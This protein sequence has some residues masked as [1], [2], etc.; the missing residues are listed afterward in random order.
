MIISPTNKIG[1]TVWYEKNGVKSYFIV[2]YIDNNCVIDGED[3]IVGIEEYPTELHNLILP[4]LGG[5]TKYQIRYNNLYNTKVDFTHCI[6]K[7]LV[8]KEE[9]E[10]SDVNDVLS[11][12]PYFCG[13]DA[14]Q[15]GRFIIFN[16]DLTRHE[17]RE[18]ID[19]ILSGE[20]NKL[21]KIFV[22]KIINFYNIKQKE[23][24]FKELTNCP[25]YRKQLEKELSTYQKGWNGNIIYHPVEIPIHISL[26]EKLK[27]EKLLANYL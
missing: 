18:Q 9:L 6:L 21:D 12:N 11:K 2:N 24:L 10:F 15:C 13:Y 3:V 19:Y 16:F 8:R 7:I 25:I 1:D 5:L 22:S 23:R 27:D 4:I 17:Y 26:R 14:S 20:Y